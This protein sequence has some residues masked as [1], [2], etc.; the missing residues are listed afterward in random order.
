M[1]LLDRIFGDR[2]AKMQPV[3]V[4][5]KNFDVEVMRSDVPVVVDIWGENCPP[6]AKME[7]IIMALAGQYEGRVKV[8]EMNARQN[9]KSMLR[10]K[11]MSTPTVLYFRPNGHLVERVSGF[12]PRH[13]HAE[14]I[15]NDLLRLGQETLK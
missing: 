1:G 13:Y 11:I 4:N 2:P 15:D 12:R 9:P 3:H 6:C 5:D 10:F 8:C 7:P 14:V